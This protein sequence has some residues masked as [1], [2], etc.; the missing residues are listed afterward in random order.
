MTFLIFVLQGFR[1]FNFNLESWLLKGLLAA[2]IGEV[3]GLL[4]LT[5]K[6]QFAKN[7]GLLKNKKNRSLKYY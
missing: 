3:G 7:P 4:T 2:T 5:I 1:L 6:L